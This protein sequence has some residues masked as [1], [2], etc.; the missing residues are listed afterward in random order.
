MSDGE[1]GPCASARHLVDRLDEPRV[2]YHAR[3]LGDTEWWMPPTTTIRCSC[4]RS[5]SRR[6]RPGSSAT[7]HTRR[8]LRAW[9]RAESPADGPR[10]LAHPADVLAD[11]ALY[12]GDAEAALAHYEAEL[13]GARSAGDPIRLVMIID[14]G[15]PCA[16]KR[17]GTR[18]GRAPC[19]GGDP[20][21][22]NAR[23]NP[24]A[25]SWRAAP[26]AERLQGRRSG[27]G[28]RA[29]RSSERDRRLCRQQLVYRDGGH[30]GCGHSRRAR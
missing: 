2:G 30:G 12:E 26:S 27:P 17:S 9:R 6:A 20:R 22:R 29:A 15:S 8:L 21:R 25:R 18:G 23:G 1:V 3:R 10:Y 11:I 4:P 7:S 28:A 13:R 5:E 14:N 24:T 19:A 16:S